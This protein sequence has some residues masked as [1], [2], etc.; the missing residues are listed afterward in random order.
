MPEESESARD[1]H[2]R[3]ARAIGAVDQSGIREF[4]L[5]RA[6]EDLRPDLV[7]RDLELMRQLQKLWFGRGYQSALKKFE[8]LT[9]EDVSNRGKNLRI[10]LLKR[11]YQRLKVL[12]DTMSQDWDRL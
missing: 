10:R 2:Y 1:Y 7:F 8:Q 11:N 3:V 4:L 9:S 6:V 5:Q 12:A